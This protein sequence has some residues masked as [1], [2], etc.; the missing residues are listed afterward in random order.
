MKT[1]FNPHQNLWFMHKN[2]P[3]LDKVSRITVIATDEEPHITYLM[4]TGI[5]RLE[6]ELFTHKSE[7]LDH[8]FEN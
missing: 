8:L 7:L 4:K 2:K 1:K 6:S 3:T 5:T